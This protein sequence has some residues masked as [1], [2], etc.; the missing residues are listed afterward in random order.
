M[1]SGGPIAATGIYPYF[2]Y[3]G[4][5]TNSTVVL[6]CAFALMNMGMAIWKIT[7]FVRYYGGF[8]T[9][10]A[11]YV[12]SI[13]LFANLSKYYCTDITK[14]SND[15]VVRFVGSLDLVQA[16]QIYPE[17]VVQ[18]LNELSMPFAI[19][20]YMLFTLYWHEMMT[21]ATVVVHPFITKM[22]IPFFIASAVLVCLQIIRSIIRN[23]SSV[24]FSLVTCKCQR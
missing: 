1:Q 23:V 22:K 21:N 4:V 9:S 6:L 16:F 15:V 18:S 7:L 17:W 3:I 11:L 14:F 19:A 2:N 20:S 13:E 10:I 5:G 24:E 12:L 8:R